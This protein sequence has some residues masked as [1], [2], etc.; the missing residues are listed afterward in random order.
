LQHSLQVRRKNLGLGTPQ[1]RIN[2][3]RSQSYNSAQYKK[4]S[5]N[6]RLS[7]SIIIYCTDNENKEAIVMLYI[8]I[9]LETQD[10]NFVQCNK[11]HQASIEKTETSV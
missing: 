7:H 11:V 1:Q 2:S 3:T 6:T 8:Y 10:K 4:K 5:A 9:K